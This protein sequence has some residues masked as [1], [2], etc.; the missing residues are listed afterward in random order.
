T[1]GELA[2]WYNEAAHLNA[3]VRVIPMIGWSRTQLWDDTGLDFVPPS[4]NIRTPDQALLYAGIGMFEATNLSVGRGTSS[5]FLLIGA[6]WIKGKNF[7]KRLALTALPGVKF[8]R[9]IFTPDKE[10]YE[11]ELCSGVRIYITDAALVRPTDLFVHVATILREL[12][13]NEF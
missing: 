2:Q 6:P 9:A 13:P 5:A 10:L 8:K 7:V 4:P 11:G 3:K 12:Y 1:A